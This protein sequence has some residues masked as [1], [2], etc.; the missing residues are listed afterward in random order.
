MT[1]RLLTMCSLCIQ[2]FKVYGAGRLTS[3]TA[4]SIC[5]SRS[6]GQ[7]E[8]ARDVGGQVTRK[9]ERIRLALFLQRLPYPTRGHFADA[10]NQIEIAESGQTAQILW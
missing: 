9:K 3:L 10:F 5:V 2:V 6:R 7:G 1:A 4:V 8:T